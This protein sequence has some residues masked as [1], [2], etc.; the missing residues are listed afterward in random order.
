M[1]VTVHLPS[2]L[3]AHA[4]GTRA[5]EAAGA[6]VGA[7]LDALVV[8]FPQ[9]G[10]RLRDAQGAPYPFVTIYL[11]DEDVRLVGGFDAAVQDGDE[12]TIVPA[13]AGG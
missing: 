7:T 11:N 3:A 4:G 6:T 1:P 5:I 12:V 13:V 10:P 2:V 9:L 8:R